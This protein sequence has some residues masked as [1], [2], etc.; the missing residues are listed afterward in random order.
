MRGHV[1]AEVLARY[2]EGDLGSRRAA[3]VAAHLSTCE[4]C[5]RTQSDL[6]AVSVLLAGMERPAMPDALAERLQLVIASESAARTAGTAAAA[7]GVA[8]PSL[9]PAASE[10]GARGS[11]AADGAQGGAAGL[12]AAEPA[13]IPGRPDLPE[14][15]TRRLGGRPRL[16]WPG[17]SSPLVLRGAAAAAAVVLLVGGGFLLARGA[18]GPQSAGT[19][20]SSGV[21][22]TPRSASGSQGHRSESRPEPAGLAGA[23]RLHYRLHGKIVTTTA[24]ASHVNFTKTRLASQVRREVASHPSFG[25]ASPVS[26]APT[27]AGLSG[28][29]GSALLGGIKIGRLNGCLSL[30]AAGR[31]VILTEVAHY[32]GKPATIIVL[33]SLTARILDV[34]VVGVAC[35]ASAPD[36][37]VRTTVPAG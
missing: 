14:R 18:A 32:L 23:A 24:L 3:S 10:A 11:G 15:T 16:R 6:T 28:G 4:R 35:S 31:Q 37:I 19:G 5:A 21:A 17:L 8:A 13:R 20:S 12:G 33:K 30:V 9:T 22:G 29:G 27:H 25:P 34:A 26:P 2:A 1:S 36:Y 7:D